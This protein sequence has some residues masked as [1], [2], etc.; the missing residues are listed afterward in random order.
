MASVWKKV[1]TAADIAGGVAAGNTTGLA[2]GQEIAAAI[3]ASSAAAGSGD[4]TEIA[5]F[6]N[7]GIIIHEDADG[8][9]TFAVGTATSGPAKIQVD[10]GDGITVGAGGVAL[11]ST[12]A[13]NGLTHSNGVINVA[14]QSGI[15]VTANAIAV[16]PDDVTIE[17]ASAT[18]DVQVKDGGISFVKL[19]DSA[20]HISTDNS[21]NFPSTD[22]ELASAR[23]IGLAF[24]NVSLLGVANGGQ[25]T[26]Y[27]QLNASGSGIQEVTMG[28]IDISDDTDFAVNNNSNNQQDVDLT[29]ANSTLTATTPGLSTSSNVQFANVNATGALSV[30]GNATIT[31]NLTVQGD[32]VTMN[33]STILV[34]D[35]IITLGNVSGADEDSA[36]NCGIQITASSSAT[37]WPELRWLKDGPLTGWHVENYKNARTGDSLHPIAVMEVKD[38]ATPIQTDESGGIGSFWF[39]KTSDA[40]YICT[41]IS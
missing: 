1:L 6:A 37:E 38:N 18:G 15:T 11:A 24:P 7:G 21:G 9:G 41:N 23:A 22:N 3:A 4:I 31:G 36:N 39:D 10:A 17:V 26:N 16:N 32:T 8:N 12:V 27:L 14:G 20:V 25:T 28:V 29:F 34:E 30:G 5:P 35:K 2:T 33:T 19:S 40:L 13:G